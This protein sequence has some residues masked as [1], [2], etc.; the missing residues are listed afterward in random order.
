ML[1]CLPENRGF[2]KKIE[3][4]K[5]VGYVRRNVSCPTVGLQPQYLKPPNFVTH[6]KPILIIFCDK[7][8]IESL[9]DPLYE[10]TWVVSLTKQRSFNDSINYILLTTIY[11]ILIS[12]FYSKTFENIFLK[13][14]LI[15]I[16]CNSD[17]ANIFIVL[18]KQKTI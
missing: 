16:V 5:K 2:V 6:M 13:L 7:Q 9:T 8:I 3:I 10:Y 14:C 17:I 11:E 18:K 12:N 1:N 15:L 4:A